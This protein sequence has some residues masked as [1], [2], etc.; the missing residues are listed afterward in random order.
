MNKY[1]VDTNIIVYTMNGLEPAVN[2]MK[3]IQDKK[4]IYS[5][6][7]EAELFSPWMLTEEDI[8]DLDS[9][10]E[11]GK[12]V[13]VN[14]LIALKAAEL[15][16]LSKRKHNRSLKLP[17]ALIAAT[18]IEY[19]AVLVTRNENDFNHLFDYGLKMFNPFSP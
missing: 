2:F 7:V 5:V 9:V 19:K 10:L 11:L 14:S 1:R 13:A 8:H 12:I 17:D 4:I 16:R 6:I 18:A 15:R 3:N